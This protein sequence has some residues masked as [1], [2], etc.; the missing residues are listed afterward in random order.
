MGDMSKDQVI[1]FACSDDLNAYPM[2]A[3]TLSQQRIISMALL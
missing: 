3:N 1:A 2:Q